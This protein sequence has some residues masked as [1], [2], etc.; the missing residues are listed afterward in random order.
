MHLIPL[1][2]AKG[3]DYGISGDCKKKRI[4]IISH[5]LLKQNSGIP[6]KAFEVFLLRS[7]KQAVMDKIHNGF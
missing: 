6:E 2:A 1:V 7:L 4:L 3:G 5:C